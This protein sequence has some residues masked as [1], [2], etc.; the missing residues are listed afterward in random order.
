MDLI[1]LP[2][3]FL[4]EIGNN[5]SLSELTKL[6][7]TNSELARRLCNNEDYWRNRY[8]FEFGNTLVPWRSRKTHSSYKIRYYQRKF[9]FRVINGTI[10]NFW[11]NIPISSIIQVNQNEYSRLFLRTD[12]QVWAAGE[13]TDG[14]LG[15]APSYSSFFH[16]DEISEPIQQIGLGSFHTLLLTNSGKVLASGNNTAFQLAESV[17][18]KERR[19]FEEII[20]PEPLIIQQIVVYHCSNWAL[21]Q[22]GRV[23]VWGRN[24]YRRLYPNSSK[25]ISRP[26]ELR[27]LPR[28][29][30]VFPFEFGAVFLDEQFRGWIH[31]TVPTFGSDRLISD[32]AITFEP[33]L[34]QIDQPIFSVVVGRNFILALTVSGQLRLS[35]SDGELENWITLQPLPFL[36]SVEMIAGSDHQVLLLEEENGKAKVLRITDSVNSITVT[37][38]LPNIDQ[39]I[40]WISVY[41]NTFYLGY[42]AK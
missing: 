41:N 24:L 23:W 31:G 12:G 40:E 3:F 9:G 22:Q 5:L 18:V 19:G 38:L 30:S 20:F 7:L 2:D 13:N 28:I 42:N 11:S 32:S 4:Y 35:I 17:D 37:G 16:L 25:K 6:C 27:N 8:Y 36:N 26:I 21:D 1:A 10:R 14:Q 33:I 34:L 15:S 39:Q 29:V